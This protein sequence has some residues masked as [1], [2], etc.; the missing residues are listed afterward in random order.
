MYFPY[1]PLRPVILCYLFLSSAGLTLDSLWQSTVVESES[2]SSGIWV[3]ARSRSLSFEGDSDSGPYLSHLDFL[4]NFVAVY[5]TYIV[6]FILQLRLCLYVLCTLY[7]D[8]FKN[9]C[10]V[11]FNYTIIVSHAVSPRVEVGV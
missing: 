2:E 9:F 6:Q 8:E 5:L 11:I 10:Q 3:L 1:E 4:C 7:I